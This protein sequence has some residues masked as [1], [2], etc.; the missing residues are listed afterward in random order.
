MTYNDLP[1]VR[2]SHLKAMAT[3]PKQY[4]HELEHPRE[5]KP[6]YLIGRA[7]H[8]LVLEGAERYAETFTTYPGKARRGKAWEDFKATVGKGRDVLIAS[9]A[10]QVGG[11]AAAVLSD[12]IAKQH[13]RDGLA[14]QTIQWT[15]EATGI[16]CKC[17]ADAVN[18]HLVE[19]KSTRNPEPDAF[20]RDAHRFLYPG[21]LAF[22][23][24]G[25]KA[26]GLKLG[27]PPALITVGTEPPHDVVVYDELG[28]ALAA[29]RRLFRRLLDELAECQKT[30]TWP[31]AA[32][33]EAMT[34]HLP[35]W[36][37]DDDEAPITFDGK[38]V[39]SG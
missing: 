5:D 26:S 22:Y 16:L 10:E 7:I 38:A 4:R 9:E 21:Q 36:A 11:C 14:E 39:F 27:R 20:A 8:C 29:G 15:D 35:P 33:G 25:A 17:R 34:L 37:I 23:E 12:P 1:G 13:L 3:S 24:E 32:R 19:L 18:G 2:W 31:G 28:E 30:D 6:A